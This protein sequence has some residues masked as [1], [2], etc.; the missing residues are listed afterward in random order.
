VKISLGGEQVFLDRINGIGWI[1]F[2]VLLMKP[3]KSNPPSAD[4]GKPSEYRQV[5][6]LLQ[7]LRQVSGLGDKQGGDGESCPFQDARNAVIRL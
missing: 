2:L 3:R 6:P 5:F 1:L 4:R 7:D